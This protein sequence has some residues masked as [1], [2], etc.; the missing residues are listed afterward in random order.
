MCERPFSAHKPP[1][2]DRAKLIQTYE[3]PARDQLN[4]HTSWTVAKP[5]LV[6]SNWTRCSW[7]WDGLFVAAQLNTVPLGEASVKLAEILLV[8]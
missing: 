7:H 5:Y 2:T 4:K 3:D 1:P 8:T 6:R